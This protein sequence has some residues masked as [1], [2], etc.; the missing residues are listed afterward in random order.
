MTLSPTH[1]L[2][3]STVTVSGSGYESAEPIQVRWNTTAP[4]AGTLVATATTTSSFFVHGTF[5]TTFTVP[6]TTRG[7]C[8]WVLAQGMTSQSYQ[9]ATFCVD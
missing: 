4:G 1:G 9:L 2:I 7:L 8:Y 5:S 3:G 6:S